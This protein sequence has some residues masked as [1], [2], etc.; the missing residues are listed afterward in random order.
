V[1]VLA[2]KVNDALGDNL[3]FLPS[4]QALRRHCPD[5]TL[6]LLAT[7]NLA[8]LYGG[9]AA[10]SRSLH[11]E[12]RA[13]DRAYRHPLRLLR[14]LA[15]A[16]ALRPGACLL[17]FD[18]SSVGHLLAKASGAPVRV[19]YQLRHIKVP[20]SVTHNV[21]I[22][23]DSRP[24]SWNWEMTSALV[25]LMGRAEGWPAA[26]IRPDL[27][28]LLTTA[29]PPKGGRPRIVIHPGSSNALTRWPAEAFAAVAQA[30]A[31]DCEVVW[32]R[33]GAAL[34]APQGSLGVQTR[35]LS[36][37][38]SWIATADLFVGNNSGP[39]HLADA[40]G[41][42]GVVVTGPTAKGWDPYWQPDRWAVLRHPSLACA[43]CEVVSKVLD[44]CVNRPEPL[45][46]LRYWKP[47]LVGDAC[48]RILE[49]TGANR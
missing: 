21:P 40:L 15:T 10:P 26:P 37:L 46:C 2:F 44:R 25:R 45:A 7:P 29:V 41:R 18:Q 38:A 14:W 1:N 17:P 30:L 36:E 11:S 47:E 48:R 22:P 23:E 24:I 6:D 20:T 5:W 31:G 19:G 4:W 9:W 28:H 49:E 35:S 43:P 32:I 12:K 3:V 39:M 42:R 27:S 8:E 33:H 13:F 34:P 16:R